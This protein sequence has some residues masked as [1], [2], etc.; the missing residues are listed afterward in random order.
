M[1]GNGPT[2]GAQLR[3]GV[4]GPEQAEAGREEAEPTFRMVCQDPAD[5]QAGLRSVQAQRRALMRVAVRYSHLSPNPPIDGA[6]TAE[7]GKGVTSAMM[8]A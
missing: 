7:G 3:F 5:G 8:G 4:A 2:I 6:R 1:L